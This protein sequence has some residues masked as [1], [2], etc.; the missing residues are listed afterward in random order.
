MSLISLKMP[1]ITGKASHQMPSKRIEIFTKASISISLK[2]PLKCY[3]FLKTRKL[4]NLIL[5]H[6]P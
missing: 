5:P 4:L 6:W 2:I 1:E 3:E